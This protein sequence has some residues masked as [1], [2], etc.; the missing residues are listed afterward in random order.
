MGCAEVIAYVRS[1][2]RPIY[3]P[4]EGSPY[5]PGQRVTVVDAVDGEVHDVSWRIGQAGTVEYLEYSC[6][7]GQS[8]P[9]DPMVGVRFEDGRLEEFWPEELSN[10]QGVQ[11]RC[12]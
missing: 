6:G 9:K 3:E 10:E 12:M 7:C 11:D 1:L 5:Q 2:A 4:V 8:Y